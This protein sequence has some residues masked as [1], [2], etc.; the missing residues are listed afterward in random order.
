MF[1]IR[2]TFT[3]SKSVLLLPLDCS[4]FASILHPGNFVG[5]VID[6]IRSIFNGVD[7]ALSALSSWLASFQPGT[8]YAA[9]VLETFKWQLVVGLRCNKLF[10]RVPE[11]LRQ[12]LATFRHTI[13]PE[14]CKKYQG[15]DPISSEAFYFQHGL[16]HLDDRV[17]TKLKGKDLL[18][19]G[20]FN[21]DSAL[22]LSEYGHAIYCIE[23]DANNFAAM[24]KVLAL[25]PRYAAN[26]HAF[27]LGM[28]DKST[29]AGGV[30]G[31]GGGARIGDG[32]QRVQLVT[33]DD[34][35]EEN[36]LT[37]G[38]MKADVEGDAF[39][40]VKGAAKSMLRFRPIFSVSCYHDFVEMYNLSLFL[41]ELLPNYHFEWHSENLVD[42]TFFELS[43]SGY[44]RE[45]LE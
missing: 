4:K 23:L 14:L 8:Q 17:K 12:Y 33:V 18:D 16:R 44:P 28:S 24:R 29:D 9:E 19:I 7:N 31:Y 41:M 26:V 2:V 43:L 5:H 39:A 3:A 38:F 13:Y 20:A 21:G 34:F 1:L 6:Q 27:H 40:V 25:N 10:S 30:S 45:A 36:N 22:A 35:V 11:T 32:G 42:W 15:I 37:L